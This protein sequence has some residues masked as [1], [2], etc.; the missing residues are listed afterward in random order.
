MVN[1]KVEHY[2]SLNPRHYQIFE[3]MKIYQSIPDD[4][5]LPAVSRHIVMRPVESSDKRRLILS[6][7]DVR[8]FSFKPFVHPFQ[9]SLLQVDSIQADQWEQIHYR[10]ANAEQHTEFKFYCLDFTAELSS[11]D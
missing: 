4:G 1:Q 11:E 8:D 5:E 2:D 7:S 10:V 3:R 9:F 6:F